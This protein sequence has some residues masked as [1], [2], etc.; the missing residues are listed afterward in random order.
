M[1][2][3]ALTAATAERCRD[4]EVLEHAHAAERQRDPLRAE[5]R[6]DGARQVFEVEVAPLD[7]VVV[8]RAH[9]DVEPFVTRIAA[10][11]FGLHEL[12]VRERTVGAAL[13]LQHRIHHRLQRQDQLAG[14][15]YRHR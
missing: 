9:R 14:L 2:S 4:H 1:T 15:F 8:G 6:D 5:E 10:H 12:H 7:E 3:V 13:E 11:E